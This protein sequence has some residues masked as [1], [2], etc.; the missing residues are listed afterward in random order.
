M[1]FQTY[2]VVHNLHSFI[3]FPKPGDRVGVIRKADGQLYFTVN[4]VNLGLAASNVPDNV[5]GVLDLY[6]QAAEASIVQPTEGEW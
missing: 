6:G 2:C 4:G 5:Y 3:S 1:Q